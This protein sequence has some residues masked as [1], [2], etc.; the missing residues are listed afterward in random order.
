MTWA[1]HFKFGNKM[2]IEKRC[3]SELARPV[4]QRSGFVK[5]VFNDDSFLFTKNLHGTEYSNIC[6]FDT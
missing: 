6:N 4:V 1:E 5:Y 2:G 3:I